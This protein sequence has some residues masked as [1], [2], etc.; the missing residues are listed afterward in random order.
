[1]GYYVLSSIEEI[2]LYPTGLQDE[3][4]IIEHHFLF[5]FSFVPSYICNVLLSIS[6]YRRRNA[7]EG[8]DLLTNMHTAGSVS[9][10]ALIHLRTVNRI[11]LDFLRIIIVID[12]TF[13]KVIW[14]DQF[15]NDSCLTGY[16]LCQL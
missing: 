10:D 9:I 14:V 1:M 5:F 16:L 11:S 4:F 8:C 6:I 13:M 12:S 7:V 2:F 3:K 15:E